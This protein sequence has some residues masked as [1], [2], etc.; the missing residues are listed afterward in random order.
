MRS[1]FKQIVKLLFF[2]HLKRCL[3]GC[4]PCV[5]QPMS[6]VSAFHIMSGTFHLIVVCFAAVPYSVSRLC[7]EDTG[8]LDT[9]VE[10]RGS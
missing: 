9:R 3:I 10:H 7:S 6:A 5:T 1:E 2:Y 4:A 8:A